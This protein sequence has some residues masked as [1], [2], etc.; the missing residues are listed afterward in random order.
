MRLE[1]NTT[2]TDAISRDMAKLEILRTKHLLLKC[3][4]RNEIG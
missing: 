2:S 4:E 3:Y 1:N